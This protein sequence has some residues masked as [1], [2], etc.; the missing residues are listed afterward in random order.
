[1]VLTMIWIDISIELNRFVLWWNKKC[2]RLLI[3]LHNSKC[4]RRSFQLS[5]HFSGVFQSIY[6]ISHWLLYIWCE[7]IARF[8]GLFIC[9]NP[10]AVMFYVVLRRKMS[11]DNLNKSRYKIVLNIPYLV[12]HIT[13][14]FIFCFWRK[15]NC[16]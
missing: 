12:D 3:F 1:M 8:N 9:V 6:Q 11:C 15:I 16:V 10:M 7:K 4:T 13:Y 2:V 14:C 5:I